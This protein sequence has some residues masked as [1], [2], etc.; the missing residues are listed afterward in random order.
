MTAAAEPSS[1]QRAI[2]PPRSGPANTRHHQRRLAR[3]VDEISL[4]VQ[5][6]APPV[7]CGSGMSSSA[8]L[9]AGA[10]GSSGIDWGAVPGPCNPAEVLGAGAGTAKQQARARRKRLQVSDG[11]ASAAVHVHNPLIGSS[12]CLLHPFNCLGSLSLK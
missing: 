5:S 3:K 1:S 7:D 2:S 8:W 12:S 4:L 6:I 11:L 10:A 9:D